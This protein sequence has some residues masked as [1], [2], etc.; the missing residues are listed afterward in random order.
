MN[1]GTGSLDGET[2]GACNGNTIKVKIVDACP[3]THP[4]NYCKTSAFGGTIP[5]RE[6]CEASGINA[7]DIATTA[8]SQLSSFVSNTVQAQVST[9]LKT[10]RPARKFIH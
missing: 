5:D 9:P 4:A 7:L 3:A 6:A 1:V 2:Q 10:W 8:R